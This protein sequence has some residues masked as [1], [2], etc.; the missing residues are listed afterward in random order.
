MLDYFQPSPSF[1]RSP[2]LFVL[3]V[4]G[5]CQL[6]GSNYLPVLPDVTA[7]LSVADLQTTILQHDVSIR[8]QFAVLEHRY[9]DRGYNKT[10]SS[11][12][13]LTSRRYHSLNKLCNYYI[14][15]LSL[16]PG[17]TFRSYE[18]MSSVTQVV[19]PK[20]AQASYLLSEKHSS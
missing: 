13:H 4:K 11:R 9:Q 1:F 3:L 20:L 19:C 16:D 6:F 7:I 10:V 8:A 17:L 14:H 12:S 2:S 5:L 18:P 15:S